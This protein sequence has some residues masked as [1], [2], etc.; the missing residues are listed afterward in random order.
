MVRVPWSRSIHD[1]DEWR[2]R[3]STR[4]PEKILLLLYLL[5]HQTPIVRA[6]PQADITLER[7]DR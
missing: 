3:N 5:S 7:F 6:I 1:D 4:R 2:N